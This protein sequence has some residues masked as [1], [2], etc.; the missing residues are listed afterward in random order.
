L[1]ITNGSILTKICQAKFSIFTNQPNKPLWEATFDDYQNRVYMPELIE[2]K[3]LPQVYRLP[4]EE[5]LRLDWSIGPFDTNKELRVP[6]FDLYTG[7][8]LG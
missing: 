1:S 4:D 2:S 6:Y 3:S 8:Y 7:Q 5:L